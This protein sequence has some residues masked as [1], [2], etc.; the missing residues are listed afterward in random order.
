MN[1]NLLVNNIRKLCKKHDVSITK[2]ESELLF[3]PGLISRWNK[4]MPAIDKIIDI[5]SYFGVSIDELVGSSKDTSELTDIGRLLILLYNRSL[6]AEIHWEI[7]DFQNPPENLTNITPYV[8]FKSESC[9][10]YFTTY[11]NGFFFLAAT[12][13]QSG[14]LQLALFTLPD[15]YCSPECICTDAN[16]LEQIYEYLDRRFSKEL[17]K[18]KSVNFINTFIEESSANDII[19]D[20]KITPMRNINEASNF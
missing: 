16:R 8:F 12:H 17:N 9:D 4:N 15:I 11:R 5:A 3:S 18:L 1:G 10:C 2:L 13:S 20:E 14:N 6:N 7:F 19:D